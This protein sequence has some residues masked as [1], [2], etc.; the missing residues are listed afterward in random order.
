MSD[1][2]KILVVQN[3]HND[4]IQLLKE[5]PNY[6]FEIIED[7]TNYETVYAQVRRPSDT[8]ITIVFA[9]A[10]TAGAYRALVTKI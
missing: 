2:K 4:G 8:T 3:I 9:S 7:A 10:V 1:K 6:E 5:N